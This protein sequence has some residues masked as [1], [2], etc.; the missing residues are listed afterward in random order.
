MKTVPRFVADFLIVGLVSAFAGSANAG[1]LED[2]VAAE[3]R[4]DCATA[5]PI[6]RSLAEQGNVQAFKRLGFFSYIGY[7]A[8]ADWLEAAKWYGKAADAGDEDAAGSLGAIGRTWRFM[9]NSP[10][11]PTIY[12]MIEKRRVSA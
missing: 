2:A 12:A 4:D 8:K 9:Y 10:M 6:Y 5:V 3:R 7:C 11:D 1:P